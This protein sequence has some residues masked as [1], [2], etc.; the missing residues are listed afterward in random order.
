MIDIAKMKEAAQRATRG[1]WLWWSSNS[2]LRLTAERGQDGG[3]LHGAKLPDGCMTVVISNEDAAHI[4][5][6]NPD[7][8]L[9]LIARITE[10][11]A[12]LTV[13]RAFSK[14]IE[15]KAD[16]GRAAGRA[17]A[18]AILVSLEPDGGIDDYIGWSSSGSPEDEGNA[19]WK[20][21]KLRELLNVDSTLADMMDK[22]LGEYYRYQGL[23][24]EA[25]RAQAFAENM[26]NSG[27]VREVLAKAGEFDLMG[28]LCRTDPAQQERA[29][30][31]LMDT[32][33]KTRSID[34][35]NARFAIEGAIYFGRQGVN[36]PPSEDHWLMPFWKIG[37]QLAA[38]SQQAAPAVPVPAQPG[39]PAPVAWLHPTGSC[40]TTD[41]WYG[42]SADPLWTP[43][44]PAAAPVAALDDARDAA[45]YRWLRDKSEPAICAFYLS[46]GKA[47]DGVKFNQTTVDKAID[48]QID[49]AIPAKAGT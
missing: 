10:L 2:H 35:E 19:C 38:A 8:V 13:L 36:V 49:A 22:A 34:Q 43:L 30:A 4:S 21:D 23:Q 5:V 27:K 17:E 7:A 48:A 18:M 20:E 16:V 6:N 1:V 46:V 40:A 9:A 44:V 41:P 32:R 45:R 28:E 47:F 14:R 26:H 39:L 42:K 15:A 31:Q 33:E 37:E 3:V 11:E 25:K 29:A 12:D 24:D